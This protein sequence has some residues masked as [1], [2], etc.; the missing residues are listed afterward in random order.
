VGAWP[1]A[2]SV[3]AAVAASDNIYYVT[4]VS[5][6]VLVHPTKPRNPPPVP[7]FISPA[8]STGSEDG[9]PVAGVACAIQ[10]ADGLTLYLRHAL[11]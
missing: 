10:R 2:A 8:T 11:G 5:D 6:C 9:H 1:L 7:V 3:A 4:Y